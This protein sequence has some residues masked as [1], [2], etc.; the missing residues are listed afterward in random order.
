[1]KLLL[2]LL[3]CVFCFGADGVRANHGSIK[4]LIDN[5]TIIRK[6]Q[7]DFLAI[8][9][10]L[11]RYQKKTRD[12]PDMSTEGG[13]VIG[14]Y[15]KNSLKKIQ[16]VF[17]GET[18]RAE[19]DYYLN[20]KGLFFVFRKQIFY[21]KPMYLKNFKIKNTNETRY[22]LY[23][24]KVIKSIKKLNTLTSLSYN[25]IEEELKQILNILNKRYI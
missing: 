10:Q 4:A 22:Y 1:M 9:K 3:I 16:C 7:S 6:I 20:N 2:V 18:G 13:E 5:L 23:G 24:A 14:Y 25:E 15:D 17:Y 11:G 12:A 21:D 19:V 8:N